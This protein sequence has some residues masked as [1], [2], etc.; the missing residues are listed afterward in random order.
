MKKSIQTSIILSTILLLLL[1]MCKKDKD[2]PHSNESPVVYSVLTDPEYEAL[3]DSVLMA[4]HYGLLE[5][6]KNSSFKSLVN[7]EVG[8]E[9]DGDVNVLL[10]VLKNNWSTLE[11]DMTSSINNNH[12]TPNKLTK[13]V[14][15]AV[16]GFEYFGMQIYPQIYIPFSDLVNLSHNPKLCLNLNDSAILPGHY[17]NGSNVYIPI[18]TDSAYASQNLCW[19]ISA[20]EII[21]SEEEYTNR[22]FLDIDS[23]T[24]APPSV[25]SNV[26]SLTYG[27]QSSKSY[28]SPTKKLFKTTREVG[29]QLQAFKPKSKKEKWGNGKAEIS[30]I[31]AQWKAN[32]ALTSINAPKL[33]KV[34]SANAFHEFILNLADFSNATPYEEI[35][36][37]WVMVFEQDIR[38]KYSKTFTPASFD[39]LSNCN[40]SHHFRSKEPIYG[41]MNC[42][43]SWWTNHYNSLGTHKINCNLNSSGNELKF[44]A[45]R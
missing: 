13:F 22:E 16:N 14:S 3:F 29:I 12:P 40:I 4:A 44:I 35:E 5:I 45:F 37:C 2:V 26:N 17:L 27:Y 34:K 21:T 33:F 36:N 32:C 6:S 30:F 43:W 38:N 18:S 41:D 42:H 19:V 7:T 10:K 31:G 11:S 23:D 25:D 39:G 20:N 9:F 24:I 28:S 1:S 8:Y 15:A